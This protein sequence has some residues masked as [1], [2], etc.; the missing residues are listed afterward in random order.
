MFTAIQLR[1]ENIVMYMTKMKISELES[2]SMVMHYDSQNDTD[3]QRPPI[4]DNKL[5]ILINFTSYAF[6][7]P[8][9][10]T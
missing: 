2:I 6:F 4:I 9:S 7:L 10:I 1:Q 8:T 5:K 3:Y